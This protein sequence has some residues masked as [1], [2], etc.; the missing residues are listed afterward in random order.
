MLQGGGLSLMAEGD[1]FCTEKGHILVST[2]GPIHIIKRQF[3][4]PFNRLYNCSS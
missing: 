2:I 4:A 3:N 1:I